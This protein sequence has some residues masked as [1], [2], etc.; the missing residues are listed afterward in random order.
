MKIFHLSQLVLLCGL[1]LFTAQPDANCFGQD[2]DP[3]KPPETQQSTEQK[4][5]DTGQAE[6]VPSSDCESPGFNCPTAYLFTDGPFFIF[7]TSCCTPDNTT[8]IQNFSNGLFLYEDVIDPAD[9]GCEASPNASEGCTCSTNRARIGDGTGTGSGGE[10]TFDPEDAVRIRPI[11]GSCDNFFV[12]VEADDSY[13]RVYNIV[14][15]RS[16]GDSYG[17]RIAIRASER[18]TNFPVLDYRT[19]KVTGSVNKL[20]VHIPMSGG[21]TEATEFMIVQKPS[22]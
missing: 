11:T 20:I 10:L 15:P 8:C 1:V 2:S 7:G 4:P 5:L 17:G 6:P 22:P 3:P 9:F 21:G 16:D 13:Y 14:Y 18:P 12:K 19:E